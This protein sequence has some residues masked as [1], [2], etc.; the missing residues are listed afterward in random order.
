MNDGQFLDDLDRCHRCITQITGSSPRFLRPPYGIISAH[1]K[2]L[3]AVNFGYS[4]VLWN[5]D[6]QDWR[7]RKA[8]ELVKVLLSSLNRGS[9]IL[10][11][12]LFPETVDAVSIVLGLTENAAEEFLT[13]S[14]L[15]DY[16]QSRH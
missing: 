16:F 5:V 11:H 1:Q 2:E 15:R 8:D 12:D 3:A 7:Q 9:V 14:R 10:L 6:T 13:V 4:T